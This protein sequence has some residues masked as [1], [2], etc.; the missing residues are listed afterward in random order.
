MRI[1][2]TNL[3]VKR[4]CLGR[5][6]P[7]PVGRKVRLEQ[8]LETRVLDFEDVT[9][10]AFRPHYALRSPPRHDT[11]SMRGKNEG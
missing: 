8:L 5:R 9:L 4:K 7:V 11:S 2:V 6:C 1:R 3:L 10:V